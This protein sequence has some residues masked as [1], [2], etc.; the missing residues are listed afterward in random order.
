MAATIFGFTGDEIKTQPGL[1]ITRGESGGW[2][3]TDE[4]VIK[5]TDL[6]SVLPDFARG[7]LLVNVDPNVPAPFDDFLAID[8]VSI[9][10]TEGDLVTLNVTATGGTAQ[11]ENDELEPDALPT[12]TLTGQLQDVPFSMHPKWKDLGAT[13]KK[14]LGLT[15]INIIQFDPATN[16][17][18][19]ISQDNTSFIENPEQFAAADAISFAT[20]IAQGQTTYQKSA[21][22]WTES[23]E[24]ADQLT[25]A[26]INKLGGIATPRGTPP[27]PAGTRDWMLTSVSQSNSGELY[28]T[29]LEWTLS[30]EGGFNDFLY[31]P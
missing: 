18:I 15:L 24:G 23:T 10:R 22:T 28:R 12:Y 2:T 26:Q 30:E 11:F 8:T 7:N 6:A 16:K 29:N 1:T 4:L 3:A 20:L 19:I 25:P 13:D 5:A 27:E 14:L 17:L 31:G 21:Y 9:V